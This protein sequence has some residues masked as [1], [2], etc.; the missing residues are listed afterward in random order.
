MDL[1]VAVLVVLATARLT[2][3]VVLDA[4]TEAMFAGLY[5]STARWPRFQE[6]LRDLITCSWCTS[7]WVGP[8]MAAVGWEWGHTAA[9]NIFTLGLAASWFTGIAGQWLDPG[10]RGFA[11]QQ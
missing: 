5:N 8:A 3:V 9:F 7:I 1:G 4:I 10:Q 2:R 6:W 11:R